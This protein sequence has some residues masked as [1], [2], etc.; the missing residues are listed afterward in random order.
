MLH[1]TP[2]WA[3]RH[4]YFHHSNPRSGDRAKK[5]FE[6]THVRPSIDW[7]RYVLKDETREADHEKAADILKRLSV[8]RGSAAMEAGRATQDACNLHLIPDK[9][10]GQT[11]SLVEATQVA[12]DRLQ[13]YEPRDWSPSVSEDDTAKKLHYIEEIPKVIEHSILGLRE[14]MR[15]DNRI[16]GEIDLLDRLPG[17]ALPHNTLP[18]YGRRGD[19]KTKWSKQSQ[20]PNAKPNTWVRGSLPSSL[21]GMFDMN[22]VYQVAGFYALN[23]RQPP[24]LVYAN[25]YDY[26]VFDGNNTPELSPLFLEDVV[27]DISFQHKITENILRQSKDKHDLFNLVS[28]DFRAIQWNEPPGYVEEA[29]RMWGFAN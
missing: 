14:A 7:A 28:P 29:K 3:A 13:N 2:D 9:D 4:K 16:V 24:F 17:N 12:I 10:F 26:R 23:G 21:S 22:N 19:L 25:A 1:T 6:K 27:R 15:H 18:D 20:R 8:G 11:L 5:L